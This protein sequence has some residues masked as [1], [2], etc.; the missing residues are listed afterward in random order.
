[1]I[2]HSA[3]SRVANV[4]WHAVRCKFMQQD[5]MVIM[6]G[7]THILMKV[8]RESTLVLVCVRDL[9]SQLD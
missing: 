6:S 4:C 8:S 5:P 9:P 7:R 1:M 2:C 3:L